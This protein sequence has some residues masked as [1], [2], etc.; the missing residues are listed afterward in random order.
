MADLLRQTP[1]TYELLR[2]NRF[3]ILFPTELGLESWMVQTCTRPKIKINS[4]ELN[5]LNGK[6]WMAGIYEWEA[7][8]IEFINAIGPSTSQKVMEW[9]RLHAESLSGRMGYAAGYKK[10]LI[11]HSLDPT[12]VAV[13]EWVL[14]NCMITNADFGDNSMEDDKAQMT[15]IT[16]QPDFCILTY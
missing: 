8:E 15:K 2:P 9:V 14:T 6:N 11:L 12:G 3:E 1:I 7:L 10:T 5:Y 4:V 13:E 16:I